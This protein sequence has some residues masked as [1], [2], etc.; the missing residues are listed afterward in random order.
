MF[1]EVVL[2]NGTYVGVIEV[3]KTAPICRELQARKLESLRATCKIVRFVV[4]ESK[5]LG[6]CLHENRRSLLKKSKVTRVV[7]GLCK[8]FLFP[9]NTVH[10]K[11]SWITKLRKVIFR[12]ERYC[13]ECTALLIK[14][15]LKY[16]LL[17]TCK[18]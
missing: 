14:K 18:T 9:S 5:V 8:V 17:H 7:H 16:Y 6:R 15:D 12:H 3:K 13:F 4:G 1:F 10:L 11:S 2:C